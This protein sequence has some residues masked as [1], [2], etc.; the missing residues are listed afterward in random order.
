[1]LI[2]GTAPL[3]L[4]DCCVT[5]RFRATFIQIAQDIKSLVTDV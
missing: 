3:D 5:R 1:M 4:Q 2:R